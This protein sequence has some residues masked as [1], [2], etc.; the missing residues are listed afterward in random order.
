MASIP[1][2]I[3]AFRAAHP[4]AYAW[5]KAE[6]PAADRESFKAAC[7]EAYSWLMSARGTAEYAR[8][9]AEGAA[10][11]RARIQS[12]EQVAL[13]GHERLIARLKYDGKTTAAQ[14]AQLMA[15]AER[16]QLARMRGL[17]SSPADHK[18]RFIQ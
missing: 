17:T 16:Q 2:Q 4:E 13:P 15:E 6:G 8:L 14:A 11:E 12:I 3:E 9:V 5:L 10:A 7:P 18:G 1:E